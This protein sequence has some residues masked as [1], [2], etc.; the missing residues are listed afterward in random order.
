MDAKPG[1][2][3]CCSRSLK[4]ALN[5]RGAFGRLATGKEVNVI[6]QVVLDLS[7]LYVI[8]FG[9]QAFGKVTM[10][11]HDPLSAPL[12]LDKRD[13]FALGVDV[14]PLQT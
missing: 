5:H 9:L 4:G 3:C 7:V 13:G 10:D 11:W 12:C 8:A 2:T 1:D 6:A 14:S